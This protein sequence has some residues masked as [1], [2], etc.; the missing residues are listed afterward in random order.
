M[1]RLVLRRRRDL[2]LQALV[3]ERHVVPHLLRLTIDVVLGDD[4]L[5]HQAIRPQLPH[6][7][8]GL[9][10]RVHL[11]LRVRGLVGLVVPEAAVADQ[12]DQHVV[13]E[14][15]AKRE[16]QAHRADAR[17]HVVG[18]DVDDWHVEALG[19]VRCP[20]RRA[21]VVGVGREADL[22]VRDQVHRAADLVA[23]ERLQVERLRDD[24]LGGE[25]RVA[26][27][28]DRDR[29]VGL[30]VGVRSFARGLGR[31]RRALDNRRDVLEMAGVGLEV[32][33]DRS[34]LGQLVGPLRAVVVLHVAGAALR[35]RRHRL[36]RRGALEL[37]EDRVVG[38]S[39]VVREHVQAPAVGHADHHLLP[40]VGR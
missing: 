22:V 7:L 5:A 39:Q 24:P 2:R 32:D 30:L 13:T 19:Q 26:V 14:L 11:R 28:H 36:Q 29:R 23:V 33:A 27:D 20:A 31:A 35:D 38:A 40:A 17:R 15:L 8:L 10:L 25:R 3:Q 16:R 1:L 12:V 9:D 37:R 6:A 18:V 4:P 21:R 34:A